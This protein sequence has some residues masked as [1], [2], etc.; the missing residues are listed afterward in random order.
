LVL[1]FNNV[2]SVLTKY[3]KLLSSKFGV[4]PHIIRGRFMDD[5]NFKNL[6]AKNSVF[7]KFLN[8]RVIFLY[9]ANFFLFF[10]YNFYKEKM[11]TIKIEDG[12]EAPLM[13]SIYIRRLSVCLFV[14]DKRQNGWIDWAQI[15]CG[16]SH[17]PR[18][19]L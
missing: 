11:F 7:I 17:N 18:E 10:F 14:T 19:G 15:F 4:V 2:L 6:P 13:P 9:S 12:R 5:Q 8:I 16:T 1:N 3:W